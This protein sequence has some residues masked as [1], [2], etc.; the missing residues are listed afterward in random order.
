[1]FASN[2]AV[3]TSIKAVEKSRAKAIRKAALFRHFD[4]CPLIKNDKK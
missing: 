3:F 2:Q 4:S 1:M